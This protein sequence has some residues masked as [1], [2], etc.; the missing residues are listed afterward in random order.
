MDLILWRHAEA[1]VLR[2]GQGDL[3]RALT[4]KGERQA[5]RMAEWLNQRLAHSTRILVSPAMRTQQTAKALDKS[6]KTVPA[7]APEA[8]AEAVLKAARWP[9][10]T[11]PVLMIGHQ[12]T[13]GQVAA[14]LL[15]GQPQAWSI[16]KGAVWWFR[17]RDR[18]GVVDTVLQAVQ[19]PDCL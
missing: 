4:P 9:D 15:S 8:T 2:D 17:R 12:P 6:F 10:A 3:E 19:A 11:E 7:L 1:H 16:K 14:L 18:E 13:L 5:Q